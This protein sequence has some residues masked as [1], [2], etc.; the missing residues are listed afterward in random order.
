M[1]KNH[2]MSQRGSVGVAFL[3]I[4]LAL[5][6]MAHLG[7]LWYE[8]AHRHLEHAI[9][10]SQTRMLGETIFAKKSAQQ[11][12]EGTY[13]WYDSGYETQPGGKRIT[14]TGISTYSKDGLMDS[15]LCRAEAEGDLGATFQLKKVHYRLPQPIIDLAQRTCLVSTL[16]YQTE[17]LPSAD[18]YIQ[19]SE[20]VDLPDNSFFIDDINS[21][22]SNLEEADI[23]ANGFDSNIYYVS[24]KE[25]TFPSDS[26]I[27]GDGVLVADKRISIGKNCRFTGRVI[28]IST[29]YD[30]IMGDNVKFDKALLLAK[31]RVVFGKRCKLNGFAYGE[32]I[33]LQG[34]GTFT[35]DEEVVLPFSTAILN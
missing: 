6:V 21:R 26:T 31:H 10:A 13:K 16:Y 33:T 15:L 30:I 24:D 19:A 29:Y 27:A 28:L 14:V 18:V 4:G 7:F 23:V 34:K 25:V 1:N 3:Y 5:T 8:H 11:W 2:V 17:N 20:E 32:S 9:T 22:E 12:E 35:Q